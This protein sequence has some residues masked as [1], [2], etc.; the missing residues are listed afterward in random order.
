MGVRLTFSHTWVT[1]GI[2]PLPNMDC[3][4][5]GFSN[6]WQDLAIMRIEPQVFAP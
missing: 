1:G 4:S 2:V 6:C 3:D 5:P